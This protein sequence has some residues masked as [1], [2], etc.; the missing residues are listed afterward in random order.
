VR[1]ILVAYDPNTGNDCFVGNW[2]IPN[3]LQTAFEDGRKTEWQSAVC[4]LATTDTL[5]RLGVGSLEI[6]WSITP[7]TDLSCSL[8]A[9]AERTGRF[10]VSF[11][12]QTQPGR[13]D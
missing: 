5:Q 3:D 11:P 2:H 6:R 1:L 9:D 8:P 13:R 10:N 7:C 12:P 4:D